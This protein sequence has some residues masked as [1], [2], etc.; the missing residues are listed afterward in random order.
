[1]LEHFQVGFVV[2][3]EVEF[4]GQI[5]VVLVGLFVVEVLVVVVVL[6]E[7]MVEVHERNFVQ[8]RG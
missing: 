8:L 6:V 1:L 4:V 5:L 3:V 2:L 7:V